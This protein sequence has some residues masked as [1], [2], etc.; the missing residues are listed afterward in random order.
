[1]PVSQATK[2]LYH[3]IM[4]RLGVHTSIAGGIY[5]SLERAHELGCTTM[6]IFSHN[7][8]GWALKYISGEDRTLFRKLKRELDIRPVFIHTS[9]LINLASP[10]DELFR[11]SIGLLKEEMNRADAIS[12]D[13]VV[14]HT[15]S[16]SGE[17]KKIARQRAIKGLKEVFKNR[18]WGAG[19]LLENTAG[20]RGDITSEIT[21]LAEVMDRVNGRISGICIDTCHAFAAGYDIRAKKGI[22]KFLEEIERYIGID[23]LKLIHLND[24]KGELG[25][26]RD[27]HEHIGLGKIGIKG[28]EE[29]FTQVPFSN[30]P[31]IL[32]TPKK[33]DKDDIRNLKKA[34]KIL[35][36][37]IGYY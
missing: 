29:F 32:E 8:R 12:A 3:K 27:R 24:S 7:P 17:D 5:K 11:K 20:E 25:S 2:I 9:Y 16:A 28:F 13:F 4:T 22:D 18:K 33:A 37:Q 6:Q 35:Q 10:S 30:V 31:L 14:L 1:M 34:K 21:E 26:H 19:L 23:K 36:R 15:G